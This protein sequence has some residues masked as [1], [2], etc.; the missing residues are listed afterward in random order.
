MGK[1]QG[2]EEEKK[3]HEEKRKGR[4][5]RKLGSDRGKERDAKN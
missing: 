3:E 5:E 1:D 4:V 2:V